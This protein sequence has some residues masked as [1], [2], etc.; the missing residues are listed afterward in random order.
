MLDKIRWNNLLQRLTGNAAPPEVFERLVA[1]YGEFRRH[2]HTATH[3]E[4]CLAEFDSAKQLCEAPDEVEF[5]IWLHDVVYEPLAA[6]NEERSA[7]IAED[8]LSRNDCPPHRMTA[9]RELILATRHDQPTLT[10]DSR[11]LADIDLSILGQKPKIYDGYEMAIRAEY[12]Q[13]PEEAY[14]SGRAKVLRGFLDRP[15]IYCTDEFERK[16][17]RQAR[18]NILRALAMLECGAAGSWR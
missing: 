18:E 5:G 9:I 12:C 8:I 13:V 3:I 6:D 17:G 1:A 7:Q 16:Y 15:A 2:Y 14:R 4:H 10:N 11:L